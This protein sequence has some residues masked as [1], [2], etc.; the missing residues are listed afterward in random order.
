VWSG[1]PDSSSRLADIV[2]RFRWFEIRD[3]PSSSAFTCCMSRSLIWLW[4]LP[5]FMLPWKTVD[6]SDMWHYA[7]KCAKCMPTVGVWAW[8][9][10]P[11]T[12][13]FHCHVDWRWFQS[14]HVI[15]N[16]EYLD[17]NVEHLVAGDVVRVSYG[18]RVPADIRILGA[19][20]FKVN[21]SRVVFHV[22]SCHSRWK[23][24]GTLLK[25]VNF[26]HI[27]IS[28]LTLH[29]QVINLAHVIRAM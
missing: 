22:N 14:A 7:T 12:S 1:H 4:L 19:N 27:V 17:V 11:L 26:I 16:G 20:G 28:S 18:D 15:R 8:F 2:A 29:K 6:D 23:S 13:L 9:T 25:V 10:V 3:Q 5:S 21:T 24:F